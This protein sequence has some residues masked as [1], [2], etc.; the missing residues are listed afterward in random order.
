MDEITDKKNA[1]NSPP[2]ENKEVNEKKQ[3]T[4]LIIS[5]LLF[6]LGWWF[7]RKLSGY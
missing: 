6:A 2:E 5:V 1:V 4:F 3:N 7:L